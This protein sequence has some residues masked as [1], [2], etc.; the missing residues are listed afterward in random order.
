MTATALA[1]F[2]AHS[3]ELEGEAGQR[4]SEL[5]ES[6][7]QHHSAEV[8]LFFQR[9]AHEADQHRAEIASLA[10]GMTL[11]TLTAWEFNWPAAE[12]P[13]TV[14]YEA[15]HYR[16][17][18]QQAMQLALAN[19]RAAQ[20]YYGAIADTSSD[21]EVARLARLFADEELLHAAELERLLQRLPAASAQ[22]FEEDDDPHMPE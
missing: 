7:A 19:E 8:A 2:L 10:Q 22:V 5:A 1:E 12:A 9:M 4:Y 11:P 3:L 21:G 20:A 6:M 14:S 13:E 16:M 18:L 15:V 17:S